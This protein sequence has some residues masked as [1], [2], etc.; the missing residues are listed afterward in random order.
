MKNLGTSV[1]SALILLV[2]AGGLLPTQASEYTLGIGDVLRITVWGHADLTT[3]VAVRPDGYLTFPLVGDIWAVDKTPRQISGELQTL[4]SEFIVK[5]QVTVI[6]TQF[7]TLH[8]QVLGEV[9]QSGYYQ[10]KAGSRLTE[11]LALAGRPQ[12]HCRS[13]QRH[14]NPLCA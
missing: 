6:V 3:E 1:V 7:R 9:R 11:V 14:G 4:L 12:R 13:Q 2:V 5:P 10:L 8:V